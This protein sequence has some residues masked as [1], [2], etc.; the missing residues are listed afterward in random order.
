MA[1]QETIVLN[2]KTKG[3]EAVEKR[4]ARIQKGTN[5]L[6]KQQAVNRALT[7][8]QQIVKKIAE[9][10]GIITRENNKQVNSQRKVNSGKKKELTLTNRIAKAGR[11]KRLAAATIGGSFPI[12]F[13]GGPGASMGGALGGFVGG[14]GAGGFAGS[15]AGSILGSIVDKTVA[16]AAKL[17]AALNPLTADIGQLTTSL[18]ENQ[19]EFGQLIKQLD[20]LG[21]TER[22]LEEATTRLAQIVGED[23]VK[24]LKDFDT[25]VVI[26]QNEAQKAFTAV[27]AL[28]AVLAGPLI[29]AINN[30]LGQ[31]NARQMY[32]A[33]MR[34]DPVFATEQKAKLQTRVDASIE[35]EAY[36]RAATTESTW[37]YPGSWGTTQ[38]K[39]DAFLKEARRS[40][41][42][43]QWGARGYSGTTEIETQKLANE[44]AA[45]MK[46]KNA[47]LHESLRN[48][49]G[50]LQPPENTGT[51][52]TGGSRASSATERADKVAQQMADLAYNREMLELKRAYIPLLGEEGRLYDIEIQKKEIGYRL[53]QQ[54]KK[55]NAGTSSTKAIEIAKAE[56]DAQSKLQDIKNKTALIDA[57]KAEK[58]DKLI[59]RL[60]LELQLAEAV[61]EEARKQLK[62]K[63]K[64]LQYS[65]LDEKDQKKIEDLLKK[66]EDAKGG[67]KFKDYMKQ[68]ETDL[69]DTEGMIVSL[70][71]TVETELGSAMSNAITGIITGTKT[72]Q[73]A[74]AEMFANIGKA[75]IDMATKMIAK[76][77]I[78]KVLGVVLGGAG[79]STADSTGSGLTTEIIAEVGKY[80]S[81]SYAEG[82][83]VTGPTN[84]MVGEG[85]EPEYVIPESKMASAM[86]RWTEG[87]RGDDVLAGGGG[88][89]S[90]N[91]LA[92]GGGDSSRGGG[93][94][95]RSGGAGSVNVL[96]GGGGD[97]SRSGGAG[98]ANVLAGKSGNASGG[99]AAINGTAAAGSTDT[100]SANNNIVDVSY[101]VTQI[102]GMNFVTEEQFQVG[103]KQAANKGGHLGSAMAL[104]KLRNSPT[105]R[106]KIGL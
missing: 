91:V 65:D 6:G 59:K 47:D 3:L 16:Q 12:L 51:G 24:A 66:T 26:L 85:G 73:E 55:I 21:D 81:S 13:G 49:V 52:G 46:L 77:L 92:G 63:L 30:I 78:L 98:S 103:M 84:A 101:S 29:K 57:Q 41:E 10:E 80:S 82:G 105:S 56:T 31:F 7:T 96:A 48:R 34:N 44:Y 60:T 88:A 32:D 90:V 68:L 102:N 62:L 69:K 4:I 72:A 100:T 93:D 70:A 39:Y 19:T 2:V 25:E 27:A 104:G 87:S 89:G 86:S 15:L 22:A 45:S 14:P 42:I 61:T 67:G 37:W 94:S 83:Y 54:I 11:S 75:F 97:S 38:E 40:D 1:V 99:S 76:A 23:G 18:G 106:R 8:E 28:A 17:G 79:G 53:A 9:I 33:K 36:T 5:K 43:S 64:M 74:F 71:Q 95:S 20:K 58:F 35:K 50:E